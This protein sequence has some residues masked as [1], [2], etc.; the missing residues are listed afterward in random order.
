MAFGAQLPVRL[1]PEVEK[2]LQEI[3][4]KTGSSK[5]ALIRLLAKTFTEHVFSN[6]KSVS[7]PPDWQALLEPADRRA[8]RSPDRADEDQLGPRLPPTHL[9]SSTKASAAAADAGKQI[10]RTIHSRRKPVQE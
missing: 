8:K 6:G 3:A 9:A 10:N 7:L 2:R 1:E 4:E 5:S